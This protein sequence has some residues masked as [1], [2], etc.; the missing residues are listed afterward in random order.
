MLLNVLVIRLAAVNVP[1]IYSAA[2]GA[3]LVSMVSC[4]GFA[5]LTIGGAMMF[6][7]YYVKSNLDFSYE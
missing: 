5:S 1:G 4:A 3:P 7:W 2:R 6:W